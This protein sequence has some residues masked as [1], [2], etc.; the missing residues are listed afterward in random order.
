MT[1]PPLPEPRPG[2]S[3]RF[4]PAFDCS[5]AAVMAV[6]LDGRLLAANAAA[7]HLLGY[8]RTELL[9]TPLARLIAPEDLPRATAVFKDGA[10]GIPRLWELTLLHKEGHRVPVRGS[11][12]PALADGQVVGVY[13]LAEA[14]TERRPVQE[15]PPAS[16]ER[17]ETLADSETLRTLG[18]MAGG[19]AHDLNQS[20]ALVAGYVE[21][22]RETLAREGAPARAREALEVVSRAALDGGQTVKRLLAFARAHHAG[23]LIDVDVAELLREVAKLT[24]PRWRDATQAEGRPISLHVA[25]DGTAPLHIVG[26]P[27]GLREALTNLVFNAVDALPHGGGICLGARRVGDW[28]EIEVNDTGIGMSA[29]VQARVFEPFFTTK[30]E[31][32]TGLGLPQVAALVQRHGGEIR[33][34]SSPG[35][36]ATFTL[37]FPVAA[38]RREPAPSGG[39]VATATT[40]PALRILAVDDEPALA[41]LAALQLGQ[42]GHA[43]EEVHSAEDAIAKLASGSYDMVVSDLGLGPGLNGWNLA[44]YV[45]THRPGVRF[46][47]ATGWGTSIDPV[48]ARCRGVQAVV[49]KPYQGDALRRAVHDACAAD[50]LACQTAS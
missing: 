3:L 36:G 46:V 21:I 17:P 25:I 27:V 5:P 16:A 40:A 31:Q 18:Q 23:E 28:V 6:Q 11:S 50:L 12:V 47:L 49:A 13:G 19:I 4:P 43:V 1:I 8:P 26:D 2:G 32:G 10:V 34:V 41:R 42:A 44:E 24:A 48:D 20:L 37:R 30:G 15:A 35:Q 33:I 22:A 14:F 9:G 7:Q 38:K 29:E 39:G 45:R